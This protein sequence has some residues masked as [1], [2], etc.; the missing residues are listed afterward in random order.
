[1]D[2]R[3]CVR[4]HLAF[5]C[6]HIEKMGLPSPGDILSRRTRKCSIL[7]LQFWLCCLGA[8]RTLLYLAL[9]ENS[10]LIREYEEKPTEGAFPLDCC[11]GLLLSQRQR[12][13]VERASFGDRPG[14]KFQLCH[15][16][17]ACS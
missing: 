15:L 5:E 2:I 16:L 8:C 4:E 1:M 3:M 13:L 11:L 6:V 17:A 9:K 10:P 14:F 12:S 7:S